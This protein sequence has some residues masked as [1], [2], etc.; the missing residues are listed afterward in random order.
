MKTL[1]AQYHKMEFRPHK[2][3]TATTEHLY[4]LANLFGIDYQAEFQPKSSSTAIQYKTVETYR[5][6]INFEFFNPPKKQRTLNRVEIHGEAFETLPLDIGNILTKM[7]KALFTLVE[8]HSRILL[9]HDVISWDTLNQYFRDESYTSECRLVSQLNDPK[10]EYAK[11]WQAGKRPSTRSNSMQGKRLTFYQ[12]DKIH[13]ELDAGTS[14]MELQLFGKTAHDFVYAT[15]ARDTDLTLRTLGVIR[16]YF[17]FKELSGDSNQC[18]RPTANFWLDIIADIPAIHLP[19]MDKP[20]PSLVGKQKKFKES[21]YS[22][23]LSLGTDAFIRTL[24]EWL[25]SQGLTVMMTPQLRLA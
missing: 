18:R 1:Y 5:G 20:T 7:E 2:D 22:R 21:L 23:L 14:E 13:P 15:V 3:F 25:E 11:T 9:P 19:R 6:L 24:T 10:N 4:A 8:V 17:E 16:S 12:A